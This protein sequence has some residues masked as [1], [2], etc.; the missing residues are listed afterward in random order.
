MKKLFGISC[1]LIAILCLANLSSCKSNDKT[2]EK[3]SASDPK[4]DLKLPEGFSATII[5]DS[6]GHLR[7]MAITDNGD[8]YA[9]LSSLKDGNGI[10]FLSDT[11]HNGTIDIKTGFG[12]LSRHRHQDQK[13]LS[14][15]F[16]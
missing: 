12:R 16:V 11:D 5:A 8:I 6:L 4:A 13:R 9:K 3:K 10:Y 14:L 1:M 15:F 7:H 2:T